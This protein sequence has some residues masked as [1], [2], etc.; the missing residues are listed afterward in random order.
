MNIFSEKKGQVSLGAAPTLVITLVVIGIVLALGATIM[1]KF[2]TAIGDG[3]TNVSTFA[4]NATSNAL[5]GIDTF[6]SFQSVIAI[7]LVSALILGL[8]A[9]ISFAR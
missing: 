9:L 1:D 6:S 5:K 7:V 8:V 2:Q 4:E 3:Q